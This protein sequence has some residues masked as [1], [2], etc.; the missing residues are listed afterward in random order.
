[1]FVLGIPKSDFL[2][3]SHLV[4][5]RLQGQLVAYRQCCKILNGNQVNLMRSV[6]LGVLSI[7]NAFWSLS[8]IGF[9]STKF[10][11]L[12]VRVRHTFDEDLFKSLK[13]FLCSLANKPK[14]KTQGKPIYFYGKIWGGQHSVTWTVD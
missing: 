9:R 11:Q 5:K 10:H 7:N 8:D 14:K 13:L 3:Q 12:Y 4:P 6:L 2:C 1:M